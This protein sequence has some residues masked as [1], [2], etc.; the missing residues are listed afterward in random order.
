MFKRLMN[1]NIIMLLYNLSVSLCFVFTTMIN[2]IINML[3]K[4]NP[5]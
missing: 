3:D 2:Y 5:R 4:V 1:L